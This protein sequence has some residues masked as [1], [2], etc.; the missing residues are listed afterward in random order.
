M[1]AANPA[2]HRPMACQQFHGTFQFRR[3][4]PVFPLEHFR[5]D[6]RAAFEL[7]RR[8]L[9]VKAR[10]E[11]THDKIVEVHNPRVP[12]N[13][14]R[15]GLQRFRGSRMLG[16]GKGACA[17]DTGSVSP[18]ERADDVADRLLRDKSRRCVLH[19]LYGQ[20]SIDAIDGV[21]MDDRT[22][23]APGS[24]PLPIVERGQ[25]CVAVLN[26]GSP[27]IPPGKGAA[28]FGKEPFHLLRTEHA[29]RG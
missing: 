2:L 18:I 5:S 12:A 24:A 16:P 13:A 4:A 26:I 11:A 10:M 19:A 20:E 22:P 25:T 3:A 1:A 9:A 7:V 21:V 15:L 14:P 29:R 27:D 8:G 17:R 28:K 6:P 23:R